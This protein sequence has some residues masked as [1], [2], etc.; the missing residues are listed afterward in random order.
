M[1]LGEEQRWM[2]EQEMRPM[3]HNHTLTDNKIIFIKSMQFPLQHIT[4]Y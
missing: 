2:N 1:I 4:V 3:T